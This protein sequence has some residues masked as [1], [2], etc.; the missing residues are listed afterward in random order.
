MGHVWGVVLKLVPVFTFENE[1]GFAN[2]TGAM[3]D[4]RLRDAMVLNVVVENGFQ[5]GPWDDS[6]CFLCHFGG[7][8][9]ETK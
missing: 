6:P 1:G 8:S 7:F 5:E 9:L 2:A 4:E 3:K